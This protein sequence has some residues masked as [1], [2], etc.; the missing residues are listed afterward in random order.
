MIKTNR[1]S[2]KSNIDKVSTQIFDF[3]MAVKNTIPYNPELYKVIKHFD[4]KKCI[5]RSKI[6]SFT[7]N[8]VQ[9]S[10]LEK[11]LMDLIQHK[12]STFKL[13]EK[14][15]Y[16]SE[17]DFMLNSLEQ[18]KYVTIKDNMVYRVTL[19]DLI[20]MS[21]PEHIFYED[22][23]KELK[24]WELG[25]AT[26]TFYLSLPFEEYHGEILFKIKFNNVMNRKTFIQ[27]N[28]Y[29]YDKYYDKYYLFLLGFLPMSDIEFTKNIKILLYS[30][31]L[32]SLIDKVNLRYTIL[33]PKIVF[34][35]FYHWANNNPPF[36][37]SFPPLWQDDSI[38][39]D[40][41]IDFN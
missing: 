26:I 12:I 24:V 17:F 21:E 2:I 39:A 28:N 15:P 11:L 40:V 29:N 4:E 37:K 30:L 18:K 6:E 7:E 22:E 9:L 25:F 31:Y 36:T 35:E 1:D 14:Y 32:I 8:R 20:Y 10:Y 13:K 38:F 23:I 3:L 19:E 5:L 27:L 41:K 16:K 34:K 33:P